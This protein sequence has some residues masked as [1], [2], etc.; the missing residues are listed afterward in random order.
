MSSPSPSQFNFSFCSSFYFHVD[1]FP[2]RS[3]L[4][5]FSFFLIPSLQF[6]GIDPKKYPEFHPYPF[7]FPD[8][9]IVLILPLFTQ[10]PH[11]KI[12]PEETPKLPYLRFAS[13]TLYPS[14]E[15]MSLAIGS[16]LRSFGYPTA[17]LICAK[18]ECESVC[19]SP[20]PPFSLLSG[21][22]ASGFGPE[23]IFSDNF[24]S[25]SQSPG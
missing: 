15:D 12:G 4:L 23:N 22:T 14:N 1:F 6:I 19:F 11:V 25:I 18:A 10:I 9:L 5:F 17:S 3:L 8:F 16:I 24:M 20:P 2:F 7:P 21:Y 13:V